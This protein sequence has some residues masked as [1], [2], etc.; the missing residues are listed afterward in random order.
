MN[1]GGKTVVGVTRAPRLLPPTFIYPSVGFPYLSCACTVAC[2]LEP[3]PDAPL[4][5]IIIS[6]TTYHLMNVPWTLNPLN[7]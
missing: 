2:G 7:G 3:S 6:H 5:S 1:K 4:H